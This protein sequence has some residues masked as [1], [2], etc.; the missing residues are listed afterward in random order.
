[1]IRCVHRTPIER[2]SNA[3]LR[4]IACAAALSQE[5]ELLLQGCHSKGY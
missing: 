1:M 5:R 4:V 3:H 2:P